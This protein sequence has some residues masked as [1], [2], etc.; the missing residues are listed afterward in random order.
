MDAYHGG[1]DWVMPA[2]KPIRAVA[3]GRVLRA[4]PRDVSTICPDGHTEKMQQEI[5]IIHTIAEPGGYAEK[6]ISY[7]AHMK[8]TFVKTGDV[9]ERGQV[10]GAAGTTGCS[11][12][13]HLHFGTTRITNTS[14]FLEYPHKFGGDCGD[15]SLPVIID[16]YGWAAPQNID[17]GAWIALGN[18]THRCTGPNAV[19]NPGAFS[20]NL[21]KKHSAP[22]NKD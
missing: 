2:G 17:P 13:N 16:P 21:W 18:R 5:Y 19:S 1:Y 10:I 9:V 8:R 15:N 11:S 22:P 3:P 7:Y 12:G 20:I 6:I 4:E 14:G